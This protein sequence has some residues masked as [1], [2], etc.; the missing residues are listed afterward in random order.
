MGFEEATLSKVSQ[1]L[2]RNIDG[3][4]SSTLQAL[5]RMHVLTRTAER[6]P[7][8]V[9]LSTVI[10]APS[11]PVRYIPPPLDPALLPFTTQS[12]TE[13]LARLVSARAPP[14]PCFE[15]LAWITE[16]HVSWDPECGL[17]SKPSKLVQRSYTMAC[18]KAEGAGGRPGVPTVLLT[19]VFLVTNSELLAVF[20]PLPATVTAPP[21]LTAE[22]TKQLR[23]GSFPTCAGQIPGP[24]QQPRSD[25]SH[26][27]LQAK[28]QRR[29]LCRS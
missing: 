27:P 28:D 4:G 2:R 8:H 29:Q 6:L 24:G 21:A 10:T 26:H 20:A 1:T 22:S 12:L 9:Q 17:A 14:E 15:S 16:G 18:G 7:A 13:M 25:R 11:S 23:I 3:R 19:K 5:A